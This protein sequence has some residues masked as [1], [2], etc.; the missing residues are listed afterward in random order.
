MTEASGPCGEL[1]DDEVDAHP[2]DMLYSILASVGRWR[3]STIMA[4]IDMDI[5]ISWSGRTSH[6]LA[7]ILKKWLPT[8]LHY[9]DPWLSSSDIQK[10]KPWEPQLAR[11]LEATSYSIVCVTAPDVAR[12]PWVNFEAGA[13]SKYVADA[14]VNPLL[15]N[16]S[17][18]DLGGLP[19]SKFQFTTFSE[20]HVR[21]LLHS[22][23]KVA[24]RPI[25][26]AAVERNLD[27]T[28]T[29]LQADVK[30]LGP[31]PSETQQF[32]S[33]DDGDDSF[34]E[35]IEE[36]ILLFVAAYPA[37]VQWRRPNVK[38]VCAVVEG[39]DIRIHHHIDRLVGARFL[40]EHL[41]TEDPTTYTITEEGRAYLVANNLV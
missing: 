38:D 31:E 16:V 9:A 35:G 14:H 2:H 13:V 32:D 30:E 29:K 24:D 37:G 6:E 5:L 4:R 26:D 23:N 36:E 17:P 18:E 27:N 11:Q 39:N 28:W 41:N 40:Y 20:E 10:G 33:D 25:T 34:L 15:V 1:N 7:K 19:L 3:S 12:A 21:L 8:A 22:I